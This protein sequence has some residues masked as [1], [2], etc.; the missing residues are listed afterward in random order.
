MAHPRDKLHTCALHTLHMRRVSCENAS[1]LNT[2]RKQGTGKKD[3]DKV[4]HSVWFI[5]FLLTLF[6]TSEFPFLFASQVFAVL[7]R[8]LLSPFFD[9]LMHFPAGAHECKSEHEHDREWDPLRAWSVRKPRVQLWHGH[10]HNCAATS[11]ALTLHPP[12]WPPTRLFA[13]RTSAS[14]YETLAL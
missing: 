6:T 8:A 5:F 7:H 11:T 1:T 10:T 14:V 4:H 9:A 3:M 2:V 12:L 13:H